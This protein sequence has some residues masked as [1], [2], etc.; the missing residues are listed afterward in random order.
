MLDYL[1]S[2]GEEF[3]D[4]FA[5]FRR[6]AGLVDYVP[7]SSGML[8]RKWVS[9]LRLQKKILDQEAQISQMTEDM[10]SGTRLHQPSSDS[11]QL[12]IAPQKLSLSGH[13]GAITVF[14]IFWGY[15]VEFRCSSSLF[16]SRFIQ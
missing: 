11:R 1:A 12:P 14:S 4:S 2:R 13:R 5:A 16:P 9:I 7:S 3:C 10:K 6:E 8:E 15:V